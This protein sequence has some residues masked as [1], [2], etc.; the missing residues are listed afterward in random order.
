[1]EQTKL[2]RW[3]RLILGGIILLFAGIIYAWSIINTPFRQI[4]SVIVDG[5]E[6]Q[7]VINAT[8]LGL[9]YTLTIIFFCLGGLSSGLLSKKTSTT[10]RLITSAVLLF[11]GFFISSNLVSHISEGGSF[12]PLYLS[13]GVLA[14]LGIGVAYNTVI[15]ATNAW[16][17]DKQ[18]VSSGILM[19][20]FGLSSLILG[21]IAD[22]M[23][24]SV[25]FGWE[26]TYV[27]LAIS[28]SVILLAAAFLVKP[29]PVGTVF[30]K[31]KKEKKT[32][33][34]GAVKD[35]S[36]IEMLKRPSFYLIFVYCTLL[37]A[38]GSAA[39]GFARDI[40]TDVGA[41]GNFALTMVGILAVFNG[42]G[43]LTCGWLFDNLEIRKTQL[44]SSIISILAPLTVVLG[45]MTRSV[46]ISL[47]GVCL[48]GVSF[49]FA[50]TTLSV[51]AAK[52]YGPKN[53]SLN[54]SMLNLI[55]IPAPFAAT[56]AGTVK[57]A[58]G[59]FFLA[60]VILTALTVI[61][62]FVNLGIRKP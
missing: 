36:V 50:P 61:G 42:L 49:G 29:P 20:G 1:M 38:S 13:Y 8:Q 25:T 16:F 51:F 17:P 30:P 26:K 62:F 12:I 7:V 40:M 11:S 23:G 54:F 28:I 18:G 21:R 60:F 55:L 35:Y 33:G 45:L 48:C 57:D 41:T 19:A 3:L 15:G 14:G 2:I 34:A 31:P 6:K 44:I 53:F 56:L 37:A 59:E 4:E 39:I 9:N 58:T 52:F 47:I 43:R 32:A 46:T 27:S 10:L 22:T 5:V 24:K